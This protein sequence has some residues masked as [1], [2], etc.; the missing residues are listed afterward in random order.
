VPLPT[1]QHW[2][3]CRRGKV[4][5]AAPYNPYTLSGVT[6]RFAVPA[7]VGMSPGDPYPA[8][9]LCV[10]ARFFGGSG[11]VDFEIRVAWLDGPGG[12]RV[13]A[14]VYGPFTIHFRAGE[15]VRDYVFRLRNVPLSGTGRYA[16]ELVPATGRRAGPLAVEFFEVV[17]P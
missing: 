3:V 9:Q 15:P 16:V 6:Y 4:A 12:G 7:A 17:Q 5:A 13:T 8:K 11:S 14:E 1:V 2:L 10:F